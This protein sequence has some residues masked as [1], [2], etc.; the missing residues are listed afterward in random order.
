MGGA[1]KYIFLFTLVLIFC[2]SDL[3]F[4]TDQWNMV[5]AICIVSMAFLSNCIVRFLSIKP[6][7]WLGSISM[8]IYLLHMTV[9]YMI[10]CR[11]ADALSLSI[12]DGSI[13]FFV[14]V[15]TTI[16]LAYTYTKFVEMRLNSVVDIF[17]KKTIG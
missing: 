6:F 9:L 5:R 13:M 7:V 12:I 15:L 2:V 10:T 1:K 14:T 3:F 16:V 11:M 17:L 8:N 4:K